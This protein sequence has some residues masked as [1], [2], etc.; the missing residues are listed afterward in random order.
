M[1][2]ALAMLAPGIGV[3][4]LPFAN[5]QG[6]LDLAIVTFFIKSLRYS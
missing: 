1:A 4:P 3:S 2:V 6:L 5:D